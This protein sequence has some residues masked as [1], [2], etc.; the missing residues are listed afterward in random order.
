MHA[1]KKFD[2]GSQRFQKHA[3]SL[4]LTTCKSHRSSCK[5]FSPGIGSDDQWQTSRK[6]PTVQAVQEKLLDCSTRTEILE[7]LTDR[8]FQLH[9]CR[10]N[11][12]LVIGIAGCPGSGKSTLARDLR[13]CINGCAGKHVSEVVPMDGFHLSR[14]QLDEMPN[15]ARAHR[16][17]G[18]HWTFDAVSFVQAIR[19]AK[20]GLSFSCPAFDHFV[21]DP[22]AE[23][24][25][26]SPECEIVLV[27]GLYLLLD[28]I[29][30][31]HLS[32][33]LDES[34][35]LATDI[36]VSLER[37]QAR[38]CVDHPLLSWDEIRKRIEYN[39]KRNAGVVLATRKRATLH[40]PNVES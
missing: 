1:S 2:T 15:P 36:G 17:R 20:G 29:P 24:I 13:D 21:G 32:N 33:F 31:S 3:R 8:V 23:A 19:N 38:Q 18:A 22:V 4:I 37:L 34:W 11:S 39:D 30:W 10:T 14:S 27:E 7:T 26:I 12:R 5:A 25:P 9:S 6:G 40:I 16:R 28:R 35:F